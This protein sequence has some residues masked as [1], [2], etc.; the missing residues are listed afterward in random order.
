MLHLYIRASLWHGMVEYGVVKMLVCTEA[1]LLQ[2]ML[3][4]TTSDGRAGLQLW[5]SLILLHEH[6]EFEFLCERASLYAQCNCEP[7]WCCSM[8]WVGW[9]TIVW[10]V[11]AVLNVS[12]CKYCRL[13]MLRH[14]TQKYLDTYNLL[15]N[16][17]ELLLW[18]VAPSYYVHSTCNF[19]SIMS[20]T[21]SWHTHAHTHTHTLHTHSCWRFCQWR[22]SSGRNRNR[23]SK[24]RLM[25]AVHMYGIVYNGWL[26]WR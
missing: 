17:F 20:S 6:L 2:A 5:L 23:Q 8:C 26:N 4:Y 19:T 14:W 25:I 13:E 9:E 12:V 21:L 10:C 3:C 18:T 11:N 24:A 22:W 7:A 16:C 15:Q 1:E